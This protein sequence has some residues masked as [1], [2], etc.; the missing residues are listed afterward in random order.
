[1]YGFLHVLNLRCHIRQSIFVVVDGDD[2]DDSVVCVVAVVR[3]L[4]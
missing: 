4:R 3:W 2:D 1:M